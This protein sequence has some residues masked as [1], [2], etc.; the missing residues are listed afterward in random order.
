M[1][2]FKILLVCV[3][4]IKAFSGSPEPRKQTIFELKLNRNYFVQ[5]NVKS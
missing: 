5:Q 3:F 1:G 4:Y 2:D